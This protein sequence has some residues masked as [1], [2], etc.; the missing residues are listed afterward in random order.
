[1][2]SSEIVVV[3]DVCEKSNNE[4]VPNDLHETSCLKVTPESRQPLGGP[5]S[6]EKSFE[7]KWKPLVGTPS[8]PPIPENILVP[9]PSPVRTISD[10]ASTIVPAPSTPSSF[11]HQRRQG[12]YV[13]RPPVWT[14]CNMD[15][16]IS[17]STEP[18][19]SMDLASSDSEEAFPSQSNPTHMLK[20][21]NRKLS[22]TH[23]NFS[24][25][26]L[27]GVCCEAQI[28]KMGK[29]L[30]EKPL[31]VNMMRAANPQIDAIHSSPGSPHGPKVSESR[32]LRSDA[33][34][35]SDDVS[36]ASVSEDAASN[37]ELPPLARIGHT[38]RAAS[39]AG[40]LRAKVPIETNTS[41]GPPAAAAG[42]A[43][44]SS[45]E[46]SDAIRI[47]P[48]LSLQRNET[49]HSNGLMT[50]SIA[51]DVPREP[52]YAIIEGPDRSIDRLPRYVDLRV[53]LTHDQSNPLLNFMTVGSFITYV[54]LTRFSDCANGT[55]R[56][57]ELPLNSRYLV[58]DIYGD[59][60]GQL[61]RLERG[62]ELGEIQ[63]SSFLGRKSKPR[64]PERMRYPGQT[65]LIGVRNNSKYIVYAPLCAFTL[66]ANEK[67]AQSQSSHGSTSTYGGIAQAAVR[68]Y[69]SE[70]EAEA[71]K[72]RFTF[73]PKSVYRQYVAYFDCR[74]KPGAV[75]DRR[76]R[77][78][79]VE[80]RNPSGRS[81]A[82][83]STTGT[84]NCA[85]NTPTQNV[86]DLFVRK[87]HINVVSISSTAKFDDMPAPGRAIL[88][89]PSDDTGSPSSGSPGF[90][91]TCPPRI[92]SLP[93]SF[94]SLSLG[95]PSE[96][97]GAPPTYLDSTRSRGNSSL[98]IRDTNLRPLPLSRNDSIM[99]SSSAERQSSAEVAAAMERSGT[100]SSSNPA[101]NSKDT[102]SVNNPVSQAGGQKSV[103]GGDLKEQRA[104]SEK[105]S[106]FGAVARNAS[107]S[108]KKLMPAL[109][110]GFSKPATKNAASEPGAQ[111][112]NSIR[113][114]LIGSCK[115]AANSWHQFKEKRHQRESI[116]PQSPHQ[117]SGP[118]NNFSQEGVG[119]QGLDHQQPSTGDEEAAGTMPIPLLDVSTT[120][121]HQ[122]LPGLRT[123]EES[124]SDADDEYQSDA[125]TNQGPGASPRTFPTPGHLG[126]HLLG[127]AP[128]ET[129]RSRLEAS[130]EELAAR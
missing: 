125:A 35:P 107:V 58:A 123:P 99:M 119:N 75:T 10:T 48:A 120:D 56:D 129:V 46:D 43:P 85:K 29:V 39:I 3:P 111:R 59:Y 9:D 36:S 7:S 127:I 40:D 25:V 21:E 11:V 22:G 79:R 114:R 104:K 30:M 52:S 94:R 83:R 17:T 91:P 54:G 8:K 47:Q 42:S 103:H 5:P 33:V 64:A 68:S 109:V 90:I 6:T 130:I 69:S 15:G 37:A 89:A 61:V 73:I 34:L 20:H 95:L 28:M 101:S 14:I 51:S 112:Q 60:W 71:V 87:K 116:L 45:P 49:G 122:S 102:S 93:S 106:K 31:M 2:D 63:P 113:K 77:S 115:H 108:V 98:R 38:S 53:G 92:P 97:L 23:L 121:P 44:S 105:S 66:T 70:A 84:I 62:L 74:A 100:R 26:K 128:D 72:D 67:K 24:G 55:A 32:G 82:L 57:F 12:E 78:S 41:T 18:P 1:M 13:P 117:P 27:Q 96:P 81:R 86:K 19:D 110:G 16:S 80:N 4:P 126:D 118:S 124:G 76:Q 65:R 88:D 50:A